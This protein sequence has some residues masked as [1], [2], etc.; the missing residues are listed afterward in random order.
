[1]IQKRVLH[2][3]AGTQSSA[4]YALMVHGEVEPCDVAIFSDLHDEPGWVYEQLEFLRSLHGPPI[5]TVSKGKLGD[6]LIRG[7]NSTGQRFTSIPAYTT[8]VEG[9]KQGITRR[10]CTFEYKIT[11]IERSIR[12]D[13]FGLEPGRPIPNG[14]SVT[15]LF[16]FSMDES[17]RAVKMQKQFARK[18]S[19]WF[20]EFPLFDDE[21]KM[22]R[23][24]CQNYMDRLY[25]ETWRSARC[26]FCPFQR[27]SHYA[28]LK[29]YDPPGFER[30]CEVDDGLRTTGAIANRDMNQAMYIHESCVP[31][32]DANLD[33]DQQSLFGDDD[34]CDQGGCFV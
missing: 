9:Q 28:E 15:C 8:F 6:D 29:V 16:G 27:N 19:N 33:K 24:D 5:E 30:A 3:G 32:R 12:R 2:L 17:K 13:V 26:V 11:P 4:I 25:G 23:Q 34:L 21:I 31:L 18:P 22:T 20:C 14:S 10:Q 1:M 7:E